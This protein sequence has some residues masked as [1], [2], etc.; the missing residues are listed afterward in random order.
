MFSKYEIQYAIADFF[1]KE[2]SSGW[3]DPHKDKWKIKC[4][5]MLKK[6]VLKLCSYPFY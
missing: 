6:E 3:K 2:I 1:L 4:P 5:F